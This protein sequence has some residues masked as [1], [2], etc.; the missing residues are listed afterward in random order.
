MLF[1]V[2]NHN[3]M[4][5]HLGQDKTLNHLMDHHFSWEFV[6]MYAGGVH[7]G[8]N[9]SEGIRQPPLKNDCSWHYPTLALGI[10]VPFDRIGMGFYQTIRE[11]HIKGNIVLI[12][13]VYLVQYLT[14][15]PLHR[16]L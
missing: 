9:F 10:L 8:A 4:V 7:H 6:V 13:V 12:L 5:G 2:A 1:R 16:P 15:V 14:T 3:P 11:V